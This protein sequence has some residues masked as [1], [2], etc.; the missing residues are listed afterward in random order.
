MTL[1]RE[2]KIQEAIAY[3][4]AILKAEEA[5]GYF[6]FGAPT[7]PLKKR[8]PNLRNYHGIARGAFAKKMYGV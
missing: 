8:K 4:V 3:S 7:K 2:E 1:S 5:R 6:R